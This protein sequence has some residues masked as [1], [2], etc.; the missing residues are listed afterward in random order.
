MKFSRY[1]NNE[2]QAEARERALTSVGYRAW[3]KYTLDG[4]WH[5]FWLVDSAKPDL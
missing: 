1:F 5:V 2:Q 4:M 3:R